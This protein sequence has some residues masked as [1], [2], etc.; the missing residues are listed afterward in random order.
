[1]QA[2]VLAAGT[3][4]SWLTLVGDYRRFFAAGGRVFE[5]SE[6]IVH[7]PLLTPCFL[8]AL[9]FLASLAISLLILRTRR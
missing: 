6:C 3:A 4:L 8:G 7:N 9:I 2:W 1:M 5:L